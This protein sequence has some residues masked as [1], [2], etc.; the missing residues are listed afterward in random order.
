MKFKEFIKLE[1]KVHDKCGTPECCGECQQA[2]EHIVKTSSGY[3]L[4]SKNTGKNLGTYP[5]KA[6]AE[7]RERQVQY[8]KHMGEDLVGLERPKGRFAANITHKINPETGEKVPDR[9]KAWVPPTGGKEGKAGR[10]GWAVRDTIEK[11]A[12]RLAAAKKA[13]R[14]TPARSS[15]TG[16]KTGIRISSSGSFIGGGAPYR[17]G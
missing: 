13:A 12:K 16:A 3:S 15:E 1:Q 10:E 14:A 8:F 9:Y 7:K 2:N 17:R 11:Q 6:G 5:T 4:R